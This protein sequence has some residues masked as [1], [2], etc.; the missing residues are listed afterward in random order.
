MKI[1]ARGRYAL[2]AVLQ[3]ST[4]HGKG[5]RAVQIQIIAD[6]QHIPARYLVQILLQLNR[7]GILNSVRGAK[8]GYVLAR[9][10]AEISVGDVIRAIEGPIEPAQC[11][12]GE[13]P[14]KCAFTH[15]CPFNKIWAEVT[16]FVA[17]VLDNT[18]FDDLRDEFNDNP[19][20]YHI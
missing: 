17:D 8:G 19:V 4:E 18:H 9:P 16:T 10:P 7:A 20:M 11:F 13:T 6:K 12:S 14:E 2:L 5:E 15:P 1:S 3:L